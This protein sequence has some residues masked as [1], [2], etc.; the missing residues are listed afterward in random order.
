MTPMLFQRINRV[1]KE[2]LDLPAKERR[3]FLMQLAR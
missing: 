1:V 3:H 2:A